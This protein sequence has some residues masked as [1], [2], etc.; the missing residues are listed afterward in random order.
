M[1]IEML[2]ES[3][4]LNE[5]FAQEMKDNVSSKVLHAIGTELQGHGISA[6]KAEFKKLPKDVQAKLKRRVKDVE[7]LARFV[8]LIHK[9]DMKA[10]K[11]LEKI[12]SQVKKNPIAADMK[13]DNGQNFREHVED[14]INRA[15]VCCYFIDTRNSSCAVISDSYDYD[16]SWYDDEGN[17]TY[18]GNNRKLNSV[19]DCVNKHGFGGYVAEIQDKMRNM[20]FDAYVIEGDE[21]EVY[22][23]K[24]RDARSASRNINDPLEPNWYSGNDLKQKRERKA[25]EMKNDKNFRED[26]KAVK[27]YI[28]NLGDIQ[29]VFKKVVDAIE[30]NNRKGINSASSE[31]SD[32]IDKYSKALT[33]LNTLEEYRD[34]YYTGNH[35]IHKD[36]MDKLK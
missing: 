28:G 36:L 12:K 35:D 20:D 1:F 18:R 31:A 25:R 3:T 19:R 17:R 33:V 9:Q 34:S 26:V 5:A 7:G 27:D 2:N 30:V 8:I 10:V 16:Y 15:S 14:L 23:R 6:Q 32:L 13:M 22:T 11:E 4:E 21:D 29:S 24:V